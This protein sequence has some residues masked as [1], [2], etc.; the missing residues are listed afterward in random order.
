MNRRKLFFFLAL[1]AGITLLLMGMY[2]SRNIVLQRLVCPKLPPIHPDAWREFGILEMLQNALLIGI[3]AV[4]CIGAAK[5][6]PFLPRIA[7]GFIALFAVFVFHEEIDYGMHF[8]KFPQHS[9]PWFQPESEWSA[10]IRNHLAFQALGAK[11]NFN[12]HNIGGINRFIKK[13]VDIFLV[14]FFVVAPFALPR[15]RN[16]WCQYLA[17]DRY[18]VFTAIAMALLSQLA[19]FLGDLEED[20]VETALEAGRT[21]SWETGAISRNLSEFRELNIYYAFLLYLIILFFFRRLPPRKTK[22]K[23]VPETPETTT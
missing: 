4:C 15:I 19:H 5:K 18:F 3:I 1:P 13:Q 17:P 8:S 21:L 23:D 20:T 22:E 14:L 9:T 11:Q 7:F 6:Q 10:E 2:F 16:R 12:L